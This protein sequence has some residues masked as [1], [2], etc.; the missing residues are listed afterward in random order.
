MSESHKSQGVPESVI[1]RRK[2]QVRKVVESLL[3]E[4]TTPR[5]HGKRT[6]TIISRDGVPEIVEVESKDSTRLA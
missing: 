6:L 2:S 4:V 5:F 1:E 3:T